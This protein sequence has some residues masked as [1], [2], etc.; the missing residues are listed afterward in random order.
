VHLRCG[1]HSQGILGQREKSE[2]IINTQSRA[3]DAFGSCWLHGVI[4]EMIGNLGNKSL[5][6]VTLPV[7]PPTFGIELT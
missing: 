2:I 4:S 6:P 5:G 3:V 7:V 1:V